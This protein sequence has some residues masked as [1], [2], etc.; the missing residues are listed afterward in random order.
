VLSWE[1]GIS[2]EVILNFLWILLSD[3]V[4]A[5]HMQPSVEWMLF[6]D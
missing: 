1:E 4:S 2:P 3:I 6:S 5:T